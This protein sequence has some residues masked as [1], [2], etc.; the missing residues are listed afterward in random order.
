M[1]I[2]KLVILEKNTNWIIKLHNTIGE[3]E[4]IKI[5]ATTSD[6]FIALELVKNLDVDAILLSIEDPKE[7][8]LITKVLNVCPNIKII[9]LTTIHD[10]DLIKSCFAAG[11]TNYV[12]KKEYSS[13]PF[14]IKDSCHKY[15][16]F[17]ILI[18]DYCFLK[19]E[20]ML[21]NLTSSEREVYD[22]IE[23]GYSRAQIQRTLFKSQNTI[24]SH[25]HNILKKMHCP[26]T[27][28][29]VEKVN[30]FSQKNINITGQEKINLPKHE[31]ITYYGKE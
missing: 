28:S 21:S 12:L 25:V 16:P 30:S 13:L 4:D 9:I 17:A 26:N 8:T 27:K 23:N 15:N 24:K 19:K 10:G 20:F 5:A 31:K 22:L 1:D 3:S 6:P 29:V 18:N 7:F 14:K 11:A 2:I